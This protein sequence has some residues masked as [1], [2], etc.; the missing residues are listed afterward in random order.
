MPDVELDEEWRRRLSRRTRVEEM[1][2]LLHDV[3]AR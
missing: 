3:A 2:T 1:A